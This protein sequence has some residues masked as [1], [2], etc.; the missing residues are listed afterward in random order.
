VRENN[1]K[2]KQPHKTNCQKDRK[3]RHA[4]IVHVSPF[5]CKC[6]LDMLCH[7]FFFGQ[8]FFQLLQGNQ[9]ICQ[10]KFFGVSIHEYQAAIMQRKEPQQL[11]CHIQAPILKFTW[12]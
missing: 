10:P 3:S 12:L 7:F 1:T 2:A 4:W 6:L 8:T 5:S 11:N 9:L